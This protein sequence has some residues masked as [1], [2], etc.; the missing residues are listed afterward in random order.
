MKKKEET[1][2]TAYREDIEE[3]LK[4]AQNN[5]QKMSGQLLQLESAINQQRGIADY[6]AFMLNT[7]E[8]PSRPAT[9]E[10]KGLEVVTNESKKG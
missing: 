4:Q 1:K 7:Y 10:T 8:L 5:I 3:Q 9:P 2:K 6:A